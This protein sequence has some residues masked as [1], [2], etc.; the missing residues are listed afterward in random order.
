MLR[1][2]HMCAWYR[3]DQKG[4]DFSPMSFA[5]RPITVRNFVVRRWNSSEL[6]TS[7]GMNFLSWCTT[8]LV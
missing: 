4:T 3:G 7:S 5:A 2:V 6:F 8:V 1:S